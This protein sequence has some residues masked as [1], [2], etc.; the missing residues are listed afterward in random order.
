MSDKKRFRRVLIVGRVVDGDEKLLEVVKSS[1][2][3]W[4]KTRFLE[5]LLLAVLQ[6]ERKEVDC[7]VLSLIESPWTTRE[8]QVIIPTFKCFDSGAP[9]EALP[10]NGLRAAIAVRSINPSL[11]IVLIVP[12][13]EIAAELKEYCDGNSIQL[14]AKPFDPKV[15][16]K[17]IERETERGETF[18]LHL[19]DGLWGLS[20]HAATDHGTRI[21]DELPPGRHVA[22]RVP[23]PFGQG[24]ACLVVPGSDWFLPEAMLQFYADG[25]I[26][27]AGAYPLVEIKPAKTV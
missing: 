25:N 22:L 27:F 17:A 14:F 1:L 3:E 6:A 16:A 7:V 4:Y 11:P 18:N 8:R 9:E 15:L 5:V 20:Y 12:T 21:L 13:E 26:G 24:D 19:S 23:D 2:G 10:D